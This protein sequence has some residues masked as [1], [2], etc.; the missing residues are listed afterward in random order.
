MRPVHFVVPDGIDDPTRPSGGNSYDRRVCA[1]LS[2]S[3]WTVH[4]HGV[5]GSWPTPDVGERAGLTAV[6]GR[7][8]DD[9][10]VVLDGLVASNVPEV[11]VPEALR[12]RLVV[13]VHMPV[14]AGTDSGTRERA[15]LSAC[16]AVVT[17]SR[18]TKAWL[19]D[20]YGLWPGR[21]HVVEPGVEAAELAPGTPGGGELLCVAAVIPDKG[22]DLLLTALAAVADRAWRLVCVGTLARDED[23]VQW[24]GKEAWARGIGDRVQFVGP[25]T[26][27]DLESA[28][29]AADAMVLASRAE[30]FGMVVIEALAHGLPVVATTVGG[31]P[32]ALGRAASGARP[33]LLVPPGDPVALAAALR[34]WLEDPA[35]RQRLRQ[36]AA[37]RRTALS[38]WSA[39][40][41]RFAGVLTEVAR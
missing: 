19:V 11:L 36:A 5:P 15:V 35:R 10:V 13:L 1:G 29:A 38:G 3:G 34:T 32:D 30:T 31:L 9:S 40:S 33:G 27:A 4:E 23:F 26:G 8:P 41:G 28:Y 18:W 37:D 17:T 22:H 7:I 20:R 39:T 14:G 2:A 24:L 12:L 25:L 16:L 6:M 21:I